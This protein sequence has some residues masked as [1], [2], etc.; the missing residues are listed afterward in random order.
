M[1][2]LSSIKIETKNSNDFPY[3]LPIF[4]N[5][6]TIDFKNPI[7]FIV[8]EN[9]T[10]KSTFL[11]GIASAV[12]F[13][14]MGGNANHNYGNK[15]NYSIEDILKLTWK[16]KTKK[17]FFFRAESFFDFSN[18]ID[19]M[20]DEDMSLCFAYGGKKL[21][22]QSHG[23]SFLSL[24]STKFKDGLFILDEPEAALS[25]ER[26]LSLVSILNNLAING[27][28]QFIIATHSPILIAT[29][30][31][32]VYEIENNKFAEKNYEET[33][34]FE[35]YKNFLNNSKRYIDYLTRE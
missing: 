33:K 15:E 14:T 34:Q 17:G 4:S 24:F 10:G 35:L 25:A 23:E 6:Q 13:N 3:N 5:N 18:Y 19:K 16:M 21:N 27:N 26:Q 7:T 28:A 30:N 11:E 8:G 22:S 2:Y 9:G 32:T 29:P 20:I 31:S 12:G 1:N